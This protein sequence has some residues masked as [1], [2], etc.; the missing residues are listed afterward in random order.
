MTADDVRY[1]LSR[2]MV[3]S[4][5]TEAPEPMP[6]PTVSQTEAIVTDMVNGVCRECDSSV[7]IL[8]L[9]TEGELREPS[10]VFGWIS[11]DDLLRMLAQPETSP[12]TC[13]DIGSEIRRRF[14][15]AKLSDIEDIAKKR[16]G[17]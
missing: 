5:S 9:C 2:P 14:T 12:Q 11:T 10:S 7:Y 17:H 13:K 3:T 4:A 1:W 16:G 6:E 15:D 8:W